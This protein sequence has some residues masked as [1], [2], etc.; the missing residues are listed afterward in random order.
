L[1]GGEEKKGEGKKR[2]RTARPQKK[3]VSNGREKLSDE[4]GLEGGGGGGGPDLPQIGGG[5]GGG[6]KKANGEPA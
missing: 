4:V 3:E 6:E 5:G 1:R 2:G